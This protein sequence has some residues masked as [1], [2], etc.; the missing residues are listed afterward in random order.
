VAKKKPNLVFS[1][2]DC[3]GNLVQLDRQTWENHVLDIVQGHPEMAGYEDL[4]K[5]IIANPYE[6]RLSTAST[7]ALAFV[8][9]RLVGPAPDGIRALVQYKSEQFEKGSLRGY[10]AT[11]YPVDII[12]YGSPK[13]GKTIYKRSR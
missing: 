7:T 11:A 6:V 9:D 2:T 13:L 1:T 12:R 8:S 3:F 5:E 4:V 10:V